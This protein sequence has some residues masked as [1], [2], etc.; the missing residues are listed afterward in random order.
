MTEQSQLDAQLA[1]IR[2][3]VLSGKMSRRAALKAAGAAAVAAT[4]AAKGMSVASAPGRHPGAG[5]RKRSSRF[6]ISAAIT[7]NPTSFDF[8]ANCTATPTRTRSKAC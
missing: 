3:D 6:S 2:A 7:T 8:N 1:Q 4:L 5:Q